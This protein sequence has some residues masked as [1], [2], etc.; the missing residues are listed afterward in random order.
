MMNLYTPLMTNLLQKSVLDTVVNYRDNPEIYQ[1]GYKI[2]ADAS[3]AFDQ[4]F[5]LLTP[6][7]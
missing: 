1:N 5:E 7:R 4:R 2:P 6:Q 3:E